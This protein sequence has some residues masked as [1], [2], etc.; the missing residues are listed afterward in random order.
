MYSIASA[1]KAHRCFFKLIIFQN[2][3]YKSWFKPSSKRECNTLTKMNG[4]SST[5]KSEANTIN[6]LIRMQARAK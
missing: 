2:V 5:L 3:I 4:H 1:R 6:K